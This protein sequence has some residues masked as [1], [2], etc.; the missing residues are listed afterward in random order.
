VGDHLLQERHG[1][2]LNGSCEVLAFEPEHFDPE[3]I[4]KFLYIAVRFLKQQNSKVN[5]LVVVQ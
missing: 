2:Q 1:S 5:F 4:E 3:R